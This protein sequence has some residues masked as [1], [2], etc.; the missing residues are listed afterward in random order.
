MRNGCSEIKD[1]STSEKREETVCR[2]CGQIHSGELD[3]PDQDQSAGRGAID[4]R[5][6]Y[7]SHLLRLQEHLQL[8]HRVQLQLPNQFAT[9]QLR[10]LSNKHQHQHPHQVFNRLL[11]HHRFHRPDGLPVQHDNQALHQ[12]HLRLDRH[13]EKDRSQQNRG[14][15]PEKDQS[16]CLNLL[17]LHPV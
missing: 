11:R 2:L 16:T 5:Q 3:R 14:T 7:Q 12:I 10:F 6:M 17:H 8:H 9:R 13:G 15:P 1:I 4:Q